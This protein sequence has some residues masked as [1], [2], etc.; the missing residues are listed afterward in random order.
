M[1]IFKCIS[2]MII[3]KKKEIIESVEEFRNISMELYLHILEPQKKKNIK[4]MNKSFSILAKLFPFSPYTIKALVFL[5][6]LYIKQNNFI[7]IIKYYKKMREKYRSS[8][9]MGVIFL[10]TAIWV[11]NWAP[12]NVE[13]SNFISMCLLDDLKFLTLRNLLIDPLLKLKLIN[14]K[15][16]ILLILLDEFTKMNNSQILFVLSSTLQIY[17]DKNSD[18]F[19]KKS[20]LSILIKMYKKLYLWDLSLKYEKIYKNIDQE[21]DSSNTLVLKKNINNTK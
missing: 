11:C 12:D 19:V 14:K 17:E 5:I 3:A 6:T 10:D 1:W 16:K 20:A 4:D 8:V 13:I 7:F 9:Y 18:I 2:M 15:N 21:N